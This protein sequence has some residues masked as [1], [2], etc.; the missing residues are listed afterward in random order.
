MN[1]TNDDV[2]NIIELLEQIKFYKPRR[3]VEI[4][5][6]CIKDLYPEEYIL[7][8]IYF[9]YYDCESLLENLKLEVQDD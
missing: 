8:N 6:D 1:L 2:K 9:N 3:F 7:N 5:N 4:L